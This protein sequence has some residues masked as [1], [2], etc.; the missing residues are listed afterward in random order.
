[1][2]YWGGSLEAKFGG[3]EPVQVRP[4]FM[5]YDYF[6]VGADVRGIDQNNDLHGRSGNPSVFQYD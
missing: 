2:D 3:A 5:R 6:L 4:N 1:V